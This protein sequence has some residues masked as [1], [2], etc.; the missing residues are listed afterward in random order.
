MPVCDAQNWGQDDLGSDE[1]IDP[2]T[3]RVFSV[4]SGTYDM[5]ALDCDQNTLY[6][7]YDLDFSS[8]QTI[9]VE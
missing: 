9:T 8:P 4:P 5:L 7:E 6:E 2:S 3:T 1:F